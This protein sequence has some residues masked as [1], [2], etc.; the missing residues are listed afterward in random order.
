M[1]VTTSCGKCD[2]G[3][4]CEAHPDQPWP[5]PD[6]SDL[7]TG[8][9]AGPGMPCDAPG[10]PFSMDPVSAKAEPKQPR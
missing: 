2:E 1:A 7:V 8:R 5:H 10:C 4:I 9:C 3:W 6:P